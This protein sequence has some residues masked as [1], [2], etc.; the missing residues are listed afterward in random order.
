MNNKKAK[1]KPVSQQRS[2]QWHLFV[3]VLAIIIVFVLV[4]ILVDT[5][6]LNVYSIF[7][8]LWEKWDVASEIEKSYVASDRQALINAIERRF[9]V[10][11][12]I[13]EMDGNLVYSSDYDG[14]YTNIKYLDKKYIRDYEQRTNFIEGDKYVVIEAD[15]TADVT[16]EYI[17]LV[18]KMPSGRTIKIYT[19]K[20]AMDQVSEIA[21]KFL[22]IMAVALVFIS[23]FINR[24]FAQRFSAPLIKISNVTEKMSQLD[25]SEKCPPTKFKETSVLSKSINKMSD[26]LD[27]ALTELQEKNR[28][29]EKDIENER[30]IDHLRTDFISSVS[31][32][33]KTPISIIQG[34]TEGVKLSLNEDPET[35]SQ[36]CDIIMDETGRMHELV[37]RLLEIIKYQSG[38]QQL[39]IEKFDIKELIDDWF[40]RNRN[41]LS[42]NDITA[43]NNISEGLCVSGD[44]MLISSVVNNLLSNA[45]S[46]VDGEKIIRVSAE[47][48]GDKCRVSIFN[49]GKNIAEKDINKIWTSFYRADKSMS[50]AAGRFCL[51]LTIVSSIQNLHKQKY[52]VKN[53]PDGVSFWFD[54]AMNV[55]IYEFND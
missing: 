44:G 19:Q 47:V 29:L 7:E 25:F 17:V 31:H 55:D 52:G 34:Y 15:N 4:V 11:I 39:H 22:V 32:E 36:Y 9:S 53:E 51:G 48:L 30:T 33:L 20:T 26:S 50:R 38:G 43:E 13:F 28:Q 46:H 45:V 27:M 14:D 12:E 18:E 10:D 37:L 41:K 6:L 49:T 54:V 5:R 23:T 2:V 1:E 8:T 35:A 16:L 24:I 42:E 40:I 3:Q 21:I